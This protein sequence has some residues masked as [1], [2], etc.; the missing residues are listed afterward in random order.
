M[1]DSNNVINLTDSECLNSLES[2]PESTDNSITN[3]NRS[4]ETYH[5]CDDNTKPICRQFV[6]QGN[7]R[8]RKRCYFY[9]PKV[10]TPIIIKKATRQ[11]GYCYCGSPQKRI[12]NQRS[13]RYR[14]DDDTVPMFFVVCSNTGRS[15]KLCM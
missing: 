7:C 10:I 3:S 13:I 4:E 15:M 5:P 8:K 11:L 14:G 12:I 2:N 1:S 9:H 6:N